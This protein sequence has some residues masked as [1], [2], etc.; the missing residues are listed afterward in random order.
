MRFLR[1][2]EEERATIKC[3]YDPDFQRGHVWTPDQ[4]RA[5]IVHILRGGKSGRRIFF[6]MPGWQGNYKGTLELID[7]KQRIEAIR[8]FLADQVC[9]WGHYYSEIKSSG[10][11]RYLM[12]RNTIKINVNNLKTRKEVLQWYL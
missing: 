2:N 1:D 12:N 4:Q 8:A 9:I 7:G 6:N 5:W 11:D 10:A 3:D